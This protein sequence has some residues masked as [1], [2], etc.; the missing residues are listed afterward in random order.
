MKEYSNET[1]QQLIQHLLEAAIKIGAVL[2]L[3]IW[4][5]NIAK[6]FINPLTWGM[7]IAVAIYP[8]H[9]KFTGLLQGRNKLSAAIITLILIFIVIGP[10]FFIIQ[11]SAENIHLMMDK[12][13]DGTFK[14][15]SPDPKVIEWPLIG[16]KVYEYWSMASLN[17]E[18]LIH[19]FS[20]QI[21]DLGT[22]LLSTGVATLMTTLQFILSVIICGVFMVHGEG[23]YQLARTISRRFSGAYG[24]E[25]TR[26]S[27]A[28]IRGVVRG[29]L[30]V[31]IIQSLLAGLGFFVADLPGAG[32]LTVL[33]LL[34]AVVQLPT[35]ILLFP[36]ILYVFSEHEPLFA[37][38]FTGWM[39]VVGLSDNVLK[40][41]LMGKGLDLPMAVVFIG[42]I[43]GMIYSGIIGL[44][45]GAVVMALGYKLFLQWLYRT[46][47]QD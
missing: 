22:W 38:L 45:V 46:E 37:S 9:L 2:L 35:F 20:P 26:L 24:D 14:V 12:M 13:N 27:V 40:P 32:I 31:A 30:G 34:I 17:L 28:T 7:I 5:F 6:P 33:C 21:K 44:F 10:V 11:M 19:S 43:G 41:I 16:N 18:E 15:P 42:A 4:C 3:I 39:I 36:V 25:L 29:V 8:L 1:L 23:A 47:V